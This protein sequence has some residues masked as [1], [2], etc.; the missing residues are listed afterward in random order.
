MST[1]PSAAEKANA[2]QL[3]FRDLVMPDNVIRFDKLYRIKRKLPGSRTPEFHRAY[4]A[5]TGFL[6]LAQANCLNCSDVTD[7]ALKLPRPVLRIVRLM[8]MELRDAQGDREP[9]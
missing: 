3:P 4:D 5:A 6:L 9:K 1:I 8:L 7:I 2:Q